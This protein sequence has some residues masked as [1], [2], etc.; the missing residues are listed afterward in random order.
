MEESSKKEAMAVL[1]VRLK[2]RLKKN[3]WINV[4]FVR[5][6]RKELHLSKS[7]MQVIRNELGLIAVPV[8]DKHYW[9]NPNGLE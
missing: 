7:D 4:K 3:P 8:G 5:R 9:V 6:V 1:K 2:V